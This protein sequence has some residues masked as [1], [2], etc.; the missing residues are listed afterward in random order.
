MSIHLYTHLKCGYLHPPKLPLIAE[1]TVKRIAPTM[2]ST[3]P[4]TIT[5]TIKVINGLNASLMNDDKS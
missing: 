1:K 3:A 5:S 2:L 4:N